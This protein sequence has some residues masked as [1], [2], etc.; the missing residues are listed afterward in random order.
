MSGNA[1]KQAVIVIEDNAFLAYELTEKMT[2]SGFDPIGPFCTYED[3]LGAVAD[4]PPSVLCVLDLDLGKEAPFGIARGDEGRRL[5]TLLESRH[6]P[7]VVYSAFSGQQPWLRELNGGVL[8]L[9]K[10]EPM[11]RVL[12]ALRSLKGDVSAD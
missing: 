11:Q 10:L 4:A 6:I 12:D 7:T 9:D 8:V 5:L 2:E 3:A 1:M